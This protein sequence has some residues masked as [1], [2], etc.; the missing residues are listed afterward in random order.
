MDLQR[1]STT[2]GHSFL[3]V[4]GIGISSWPGGECFLANTLASGARLDD[5]GYR[6]QNPLEVATLGPSSPAKHAKGLL[7]SLA[8]LAGD[9][10]QDGESIA[11]GRGE[12][13]SRGLDMGPRALATPHKISS[14]GAASLAKYPHQLSQNSGEES[15]DHLFDVAILASLLMLLLLL[16]LLVLL[17]GLLTVARLV[18]AVW[19]V[20]LPVVGMVHVNRASSQIDH[21]A[22]LVGFG[23]IL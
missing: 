23:L 22:A 9:K 14:Q 12:S 15:A 16:V 1:P 18:S 20:G 3:S 4:A 2:P 19:L 6:C 5:H 7:T 11:F 13:G 8:S 21:D 10:S 17:L